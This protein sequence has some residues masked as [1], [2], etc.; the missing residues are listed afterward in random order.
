MISPLVSASWLK[1]NLAHVKTLDGNSHLPAT[2]RD[3]NAEFAAARIPGAC[4][5]DIDVVADPHTSLPHTI[6]SADL[7]AHAVTAMGISDDDHVVIY[8]DSAI[9]PA[10]RVW[11]MFR[12]FGHERVSVLDGGVAAWRA[13]DGPMDT[14]PFGAPA[15]GRF[16]VRASVGAQIIDQATILALI[17]AGNLGQLADARPTPRFTGDEKE[18]RPGLRSG[19]IPGSFNVPL[20]S[21]V[22]DD[23]TFKSIADIKDAFLAGGIDP[24]RP[25]I[26]SCGS[27]VTACGLAL[28]LALAGN[29]QVFVYDGSWTEWGSSDAPLETGRAAVCAPKP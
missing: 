16:S 12:L 25:M 19:H 15:A 10:T 3:A 18:P 14:G 9:M 23:G 8:D 17:A 29:E 4:R 1:D 27:G 26:T 22:E 24:N 28:G 20:K 11:W 21:L 2:G 13:V 6:P 7:F 5:F